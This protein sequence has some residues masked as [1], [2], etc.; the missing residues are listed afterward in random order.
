LVS[1]ADRIK[2]SADACGSGRRLVTASLQDDLREWVTL[3]ACVCA[4]VSAFPPSLTWQSSECTHSHVRAMVPSS[5][6]GVLYQCYAEPPRPAQCHAFIDTFFHHG[7][8][9]TSFFITLGMS[10]SSCIF[11][12][13]FL[14]PTEESEHSNIERLE[15][16]FLHC[17]HIRCPNYLHSHPHPE[18][19]TA[20]TIQANT[21]P[22]GLDSRTSVRP[23]PLGNACVLVDFLGRS[24]VG[25]LS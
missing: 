23:S 8:L 24:H 3:L 6:R 9:S 7:L 5:R 19:V 11:M 13:S 10:Q 16:S 17:L 22:I 21:L 18:H 14:V 15:E 25:E 1:S 2:C 12:S 4:G 20:E